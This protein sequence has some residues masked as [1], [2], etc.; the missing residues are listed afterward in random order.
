MNGW[1]EEP[2]PGVE[3]VLEWDVPEFGFGRQG[4]AGWEPERGEARPSAGNYEGVGDDNP[5]LA[6]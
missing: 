6:P 2:L 4:W 5:Y 1:A 3:S